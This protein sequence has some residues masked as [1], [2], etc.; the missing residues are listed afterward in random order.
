[1][2]TRSTRQW[3]VLDAEAGWEG[4]AEVK[5]WSAMVR[6]DRPGSEGRGPVG[7]PLRQGHV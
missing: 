6:A 4:D 5:A 3:A 2:W 7:A 1:M